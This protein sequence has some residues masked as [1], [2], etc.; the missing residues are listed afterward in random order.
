M[1]RKANIFLIYFLANTLAAGT[2][3][4]NSQIVTENILKKIS[5]S[6]VSIHAYHRKNN[7]VIEKIGTGFVYDNDGFI[8]TQASIISGSDSITVQLNNGF[9][10]KA[11][12]IYFNYDQKIAILYINYNNL[13][14]I[15]L[16]RNIK[17][18][19][20]DK[21][22]IIG[23][24]LGVFPSLTIAKFTGYDDNSG[25][26]KIDN[27]IFPPG[28]SGSPVI[29]YNGTLV[30]MLIGNIRKINDPLLSLKNEGF[31]I[32]CRKIN[33]IFMKII[34]N[35]K[36]NE[37]WAGVSVTNL[38]GKDYG[39]G[40]LVVDA[41]PKGPFEEA[42]ISKGDTLIEFQG[43]SIINIRHMTNMIKDAKPND[44]VIF[45]IKKGKM[46]INRIVKMRKPPW[47]KN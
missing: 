41:A 26:I 16:S 37:S 47:E 11:W 31:A 2:L 17:I 42:G 23:N 10:K 4:T 25:I 28:N 8:V 33:D 46:K 3:D 38:I 27:A 6:V 9:R 12:K 15:P 19:R 21:L 7:V 34:N 35:L 32:S 45:T 43:L 44:K 24:S 36:N 29:N 22:F 20:N 13:T 1:I 39:K 14:P 30:G 5:N 40:V 18:N